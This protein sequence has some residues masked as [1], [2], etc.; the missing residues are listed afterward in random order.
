VNTGA[1]SRA[2]TLL[3]LRTLLNDV[4]Y[5][6]VNEFPKERTATIDDNSIQ[7]PIALNL[8]AD[9]GQPQGREGRQVVEPGM[10]R[11]IRE[12]QALARGCEPQ[13]VRAKAVQEGRV[14]EGGR[15]L[16]RLARL[17]LGE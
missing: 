6:F 12:H 3:S 9:R 15:R 11:E 5:V 16:L 4:L 14:P 2:V 1:H 7:P 8:L 10:G 13:T 17:Q